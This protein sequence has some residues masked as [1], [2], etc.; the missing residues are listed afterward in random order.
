[1]ED[2]ITV[3]QWSYIIGLFHGDGHMRKGTRNRGTVSIG[4]SQGDRDIID[5]LSELLPYKSTVFEGYREYDIMIEG[6]PRVTGI[7][8]Q[9]GIRMHTM[10]ARDAFFRLGMPYGAKSWT[11]EPPTWDYSRTDYIRGLVDADG[12]LGVTSK[13]FPFLS[14]TTASEAIKDEFCAFIEEHTGVKKVVNRNKRDNIYNI[15]MFCED[16]QK[17]IALMY[18][19]GAIALERKRRSAEEATKWVRPPGSKKQFHQQPWTEEDNEVVLN[20]SVEDAMRILGRERATVLARRDFLKK[21]GCLLPP[22]SSRNWTDEQDNVVRSR[23]PQEASFLTGHP[24]QAV[25]R[26]RWVL[27][28]RGYEVV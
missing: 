6:R 25:Y 4:L 24:L 21:K 20:N 10:E 16:A 27:R 28:N 8:H 18:Y 26:R 23:S 14:I 7:H 1:M 17:L 19:E 9:V 5:V 11:V 2:E 15:S 12:S 13:G 22:P 3:E